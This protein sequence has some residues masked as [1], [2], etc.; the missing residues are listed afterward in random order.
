MQIPLEITYLDVEKTDALET[1]IREKV[2]KLEQVC[3]YMNSCRVGI[4][5]THERPKSGSPYRV[6][7]D[8]TVPPSHEIVAVKNPGEGNQYDPLEAV[9]RSAFD[10]AR[11][12]L[13]KLTEKQRDEVKSHPE[14]ELGAI[15]T[16]LFP[17]QEYGFIRAVDS[18]EEI[19]FHR[20]SVINNDFDR[21]EVGT[22]VR[23]VA[24]QDEE[25]LLRAS[26]VQIV[27]KPGANISKIDEEAIERP[28]GWK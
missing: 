4:E 11:R 13:V 25:G 18:D 28:L 10:A 23:Y 14:Q 24:L 12:Q 9:I 16:K 2:A 7:I 27:D 6:R 3:N 8:I 1:L 20:N 26:T 15:V 21:I 19:Y 17:E 22:G 5:K